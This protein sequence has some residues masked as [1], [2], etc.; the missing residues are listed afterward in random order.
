MAIVRMKKLTLAV[1]DSIR[2]ELLNELQ[3][4]DSVHIDALDYQDSEEAKAKDAWA[5]DL[6]AVQ[7]DTLGL[8]EIRREIAG[9]LTKIKELY[10][11]SAPEFEIT[12]QETLD[13]L[14]SKY[15]FEETAK[16][17][18]A[19]DRE[20]R[21]S[22]AAIA[23]LEQE[24]NI[25]SQWV[26]VVDNFDPIQGKSEF[27]RG[28]VGQIT[29]AAFED[30]RY[31]LA[32]ATDLADVLIAWTADREVFCYVLASI[33][34]WDAVNTVLREKPFNVLNIT[35]R[36]GETAQILKDLDAEIEHHTQRYHHALQGWKAY[37]E[38]IKD[39]SLIHDILE[40]EL[41]KKKA[42][43]L[44]VATDSVSFFRG[45]VPEEALPKVE[46]ILS[47]YK[48][49]DVSISDPSEDE[50]DKVPVSLKNNGLTQPFAVLTTMYGTPMYGET[51]DPTPHLS[52]FYFVYYGMCMGD[53]LY[54]A[55]LLLFSLVMVFCNN[56]NKN[57]ANFYALL[58]WSGFSAVIAGI[59]F[60]AYAGD[61]FTKY[62][63]V[64]FLENLSFKFNDGSAFFDKPLFVLFV[65]LLLGAAQLWYGYFIKF[66]IS[67]KKNGLTALCS[68]LPWL[69][70]L[71]GF[72]GWA[73][74][75]WIAGMAGMQ[76]VSENTTQIFFLLMKIG[77]VLI[78]INA[79]RIG[80]QKNFVSGIIGPLA[81]LWDLY[82]LSGYLSNLLSYA[83]LLALGLSSGIISNVFN[84]LGFGMIDSLSAI[85]PVLSVF[86]IALLI[87]LHTFN[88]ILGGFGAFVHALRLQFVE[89]FGQFMEG[90]GKDYTPLARRGSHYTVK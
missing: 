8:E 67:L 73:V 43:A 22:E 68:E 72:F 41:Q 90:G 46:A 29:E 47:M 56:A 71:A 26:G 40:I 65:S 17:L 49:I 64:P 35:R 9:A 77:A 63:P 16:K 70:L 13:M 76:L 48:N 38:K 42:G 19:L 58:A 15:D 12:S 59:L 39:L 85:N 28:V 44:A 51:V 6:K 5:A 3:A 18:K 80:F 75:V 57:A 32:E 86:G 7:A 14:R 55:V 54:G 79:V 37:S 30:F 45:W 24:R 60:G 1:D 74:F 78:I 20:T 23:G 34:V 2:D 21:E 53:A 88:L 84:Q 62:M 50:Y 4:T 10:N 31:S 81:G 83:R 66:I 33:D 69:V 27:L 89:F 11:I 25:I 82:G 87:F 36:S 52:L 61:L